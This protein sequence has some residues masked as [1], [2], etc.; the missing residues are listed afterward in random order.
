MHLH[1]CSSGNEVLGAHLQPESLDESKYQ[2]Y[3]REV[4]SDLMENV[5]NDIKWRMCFQHDR[6]SVSFCTGSTIW[7]S[8]FQTNGLISVILYLGQ[9]S[10]PN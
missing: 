8:L 2:T 7:T 4:L 6:G 5:P 9:H 1:S 3:Q 10:D